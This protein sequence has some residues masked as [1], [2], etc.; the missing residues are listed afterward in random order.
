MAFVLQKSDAW[1]LFLAGC[2]I[3]LALVANGYPVI[4]KMDHQRHILNSRRLVGR[5]GLTDLCLFTEARY[6]RHRSQT[7]LHAPF[8]DHPLSLP[9]FPSESHVCPPVH[10]KTVSRHEVDSTAKILP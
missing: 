6:T 4:H 1:L 7:D 3:L 5:L 8:Q 10:L 9:H 2:I